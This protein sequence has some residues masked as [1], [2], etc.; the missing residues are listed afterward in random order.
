MAGSV[1]GWAER[2]PGIDEPCP[3]AGRWLWTHRHGREERYCLKH[4][5]EL[6]TAL[7]DGIASRMDARTRARQAELAQRRN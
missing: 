2:C 6:L 3:R 1:N 4:V 5:M 7:A